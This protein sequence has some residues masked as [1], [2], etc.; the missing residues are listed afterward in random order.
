MKS[1]IRSPLN[2]LLLISLLLVTSCEQ[3]HQT[4]PD[5]PPDAFEV[6]TLA[7]AW[8]LVSADHFFEADLFITAN[9]KGVEYSAIGSIQ[10]TEF[11]FN[12]IDFDA[13]EGTLAFQGRTY[14]RRVT[15][16]I[17]SPCA[18]YPDEG[19]I[20][21][22]LVDG[23]IPL[24][25]KTMYD[26]EKGVF[27]ERHSV[28]HERSKFESMIYEFVVENGRVFFYDEDPDDRFSYTDTERSMWI[29]SYQQPNWFERRFTISFINEIVWQ[30]KVDD[31][32][33][34]KDTKQIITYDSDNQQDYGTSNPLI[35]LLFNDDSEWFGKLNYLN[36]IKAVWKEEI[37]IV[38]MTID[39][40]DRAKR[41]Y[42]T[43][44]LPDYRL[45]LI[46]HINP[47][48]TDKFKQCWDDYLTVRE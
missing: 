19:M 17:E 30:H 37:G 27:L 6:S 46:S 31:A 48:K 14:K 21:I 38:S 10:Q 1:V 23:N 28:W 45:Q 11:D 47:Y 34:I 36:L 12:E 35:G 8:T 18:Y 39:G 7:G 42:L 33:E 26:N 4:A 41:A 43:W 29:Y 2:Q 25:V 3:L 20:K 24:C 5:V 22:F 16:P 44:N 9:G 32:N 40:Y 13:T 15:S